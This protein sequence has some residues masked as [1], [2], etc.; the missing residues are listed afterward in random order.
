MRQDDILFSF[1]KYTKDVKVI[2][3]FTKDFKCDMY[4]IPKGSVIYLNNRGYWHLL[5]EDK[6]YL[7]GKN[8]PIEIWQTQGV[9]KQIEAV[10]VKAK[11]E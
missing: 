6:E 8:C 10:F 3:E 5:S 7:L 11:E 4:A 9:V 2:F 1:Y